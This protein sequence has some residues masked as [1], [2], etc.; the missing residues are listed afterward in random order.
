MLVLLDKGIALLPARFLQGM[1]NPIFL[2]LMWRSGQI[3][4]TLAENT[5]PLP[6]T[7][8]DKIEKDGNNFVI[9]PLTRENIFTKEELPYATFVFNKKDLTARLVTN[10]P[11]E[12]QK[13][14]T[15][16]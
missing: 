7:S 16:F 6:A 12:Y 11:E 15:E 3:A 9:C 4:K 1:K 13:I 5:R 2:Y 8:W 10:V 14:G